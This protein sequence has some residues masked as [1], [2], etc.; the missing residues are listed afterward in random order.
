MHPT[1]AEE[2]SASKRWIRPAAL[3]AG[4][5]ILIAAG[6]WL[7]GYLAMIRWFMPRIRSR[8]KARA[9][10]RAMVTGQVVDTITNIKTVKLFAHDA[11][12]DR[13]AIDAMENYWGSAVDYGWLSASFRFWLMALGGLLPIVLVGTTLLFWSQGAASAGNIAAAGA[14]ALRLSISA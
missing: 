4:L 1:D 3:V 13:A 8:S 7:I 10:A 14:I 5:A 9:G 11:H 6:V 12:E 2:D